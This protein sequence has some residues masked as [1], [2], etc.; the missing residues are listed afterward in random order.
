MANPRDDLAGS[1]FS[2]ERA[3]ADDF[4]AIV[5]LYGQAQWRAPDSGGEFWVARRADDPIAVASVID[6]PDGYAFLDAI[7]VSQSSRRSG[8]GR[9]LLTE[10]LTTRETDW[11]LECRHE[12]IPL[13]ASHAFVVE[14]DE[15]VPEWVRQRVGT[16][17]RP[18]TYLRRR[19]NAP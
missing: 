2:I 9:R 15:H 1:L 16:R 7:V 5:D 12:L 14:Q 8:V 6:S 11:W 4:A 3:L 18:T 13:Y 10:I 17:A 19:S